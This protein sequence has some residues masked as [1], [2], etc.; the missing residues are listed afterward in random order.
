MSAPEFDEKAANEAA[1]SRISPSPTGFVQMNGLSWIGQ[2]HKR[3]V[4]GA[5]WQH[6][7]DIVRVQELVEA[8]EKIAKGSPSFATSCAKQALAKF[9][10][11]K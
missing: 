8:L 6:S 1:N 10:G 7:Q 3:F 5:R 4:E 9:R 2:Q 11:E